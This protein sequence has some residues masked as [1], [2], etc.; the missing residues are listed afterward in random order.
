MFPESPRFSFSK[1]RF[2]EAKTSLKSVARINGVSNYNPDNF[3]FDSE[4]Q[5]DL[6]ALMQQ[7]DLGISEDRRSVLT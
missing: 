4:Q 2:L 3:K 5:V 6:I 1:D 7:Q